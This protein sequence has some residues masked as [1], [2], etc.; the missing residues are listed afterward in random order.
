MNT[1][2]TLKRLPIG[3]EMTKS[4]IFNICV[5][6]VNKADELIDATIIA[7]QKG[8]TKTFND[9]IVKMAQ[10][11]VLT[12]DELADIVNRIDND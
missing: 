12:R 9:L 4:E 5:N 6:L 1:R 2:I 3:E 8:D 11:L 10:R 7:N